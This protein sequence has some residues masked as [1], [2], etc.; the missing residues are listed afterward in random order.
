MVF[1]CLLCHPFGVETLT[2]PI[3]YNHIT[4]SGLKYFVL[5]PCCCLSTAVYL[6]KNKQYAAGF[7]QIIGFVYWLIIIEQNKKIANK[8]YA[9]GF[10]QMI[11]FVYWLIIIEQNKK[12]APQTPFL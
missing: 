10:G 8:Q 2:L 12:I 1:D 7:W 5:K 11:G 3:F 9:A 4:P 6:A